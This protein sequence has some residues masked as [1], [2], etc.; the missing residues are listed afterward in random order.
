M[1]ASIRGVLTRGNHMNRFKIIAAALVTTA[2]ASPAAAA[3]QDFVLVNATG[4][5]IEQVYVSPSKAA[6]WEEDVM[7]QDILE[8]GSRVTINFDRAEDTCRWDMK[9]VC[10]DG[11]TAEWQGFNLCEVS[12]IVV[13]YDRD[14]CTTS[15]EYE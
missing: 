10:D 2:F 9:A 4:Y 7:G 12:V 14:S 15:A 3:Q 5:N 11:E 8:N 13:S 1:S 6:T